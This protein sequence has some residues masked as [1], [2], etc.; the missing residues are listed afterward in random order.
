MEY[1]K[2]LIVSHANQIINAPRN[3][4][5]NTVQDSIV[6]DSYGSIKY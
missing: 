1:F 4:Y 3:T 5:C 6:T 2:S